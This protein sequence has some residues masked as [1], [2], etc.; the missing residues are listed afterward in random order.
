MSNNDYTYDENS[1]TQRNVVNDRNVMS[2]DEKNSA[3]N[4]PVR[5]N[6]T[7]VPVTGEGGQ[8]GWIRGEEINDLKNRWRDIQAKFVDEPRASV[9]QADALVADTLVRLEKSFSDHRAS[10]TD[11]KDIST[12][13]LRVALQSYRTFLNRL[14]T[15]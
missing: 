14:L 4:M 6:Q 9:E 12:E 3:Q 7:N 13:E 15:L 10:L 2:D 1:A 8:L 5:T 11:N